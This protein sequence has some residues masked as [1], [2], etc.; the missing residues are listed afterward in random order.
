MALGYID[1]SGT[2]RGALPLSS[3]ALD[4]SMAREVEWR[5]A[6]PAEPTAASYT[7]LA[8]LVGLLLEETRLIP[9]VIRTEPIGVDIDQKTGVVLDARL[10]PTRLCAAAWVGGNVYIGCGALLMPHDQRY[11]CGQVVSNKQAEITCHDARVADLSP[12]IGCDGLEKL[13][14]SGTSV[15]DLTPLTSIDRL[16]DLDVSRTA[17]SDLRPLRDSYMARL[18]IE[19]SRVHVMWPLVQMPFLVDLVARDVVAPDAEWERLAPFRHSL[20]R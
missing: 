4:A 12:L 13:D 18:N 9:E 14:L 11:F 17:V 19:G 6:L 20:H 3:V 16:D 7:A 2:I 8:E 1:V 5:I 10:D 15:R